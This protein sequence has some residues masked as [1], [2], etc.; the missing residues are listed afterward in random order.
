MQIKGDHTVKPE[1]QGAVR[2]G[3]PGLESGTRGAHMGTGQ[4]Q[5]GFGL[6]IS[7]QACIWLAGKTLR[8]EGLN[9]LPAASIR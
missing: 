6:R 5:A 8:Q 3:E 9:T 2:K 7:E 1:M 4:D